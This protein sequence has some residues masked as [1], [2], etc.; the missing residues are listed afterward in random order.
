MKIIPLEWDSQFFDMNIGK[1]EFDKLGQESWVEL[2][3]AKLCEGSI[4]RGKFGVGCERVVTF[5]SSPRL[6]DKIRGQRHYE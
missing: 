1:V 5:K 2:K 3:E 4:N 6:M